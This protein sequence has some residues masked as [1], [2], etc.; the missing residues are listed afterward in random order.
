MK[1]SDYKASTNI[2]EESSEE[3]QMFFDLAPDLLCIAG[4]DGSF[5]KVNKAFT[6]VLGYSSSELI[7]RPF[8]ELIHPEDLQATLDILGHLSNGNEA[9]NF[10]NR[11]IC[12]DGSYRIMNWSAHPEPSKGLIYAA[13]RDLTE[14]RAKEAELLKVN[15]ELIVAERLAKEERTKSI[16][17]AKMASLGEM[18]AG[19]AHEINNPLTIITGMV[20]LI[21][22][23]AQDK[24]NLERKVTAI[25]NASMR[26]AK[27]ISGLRK[28]SQMNE[29]ID[30]EFVKLK[31]ILDDAMILASGK[32]LRSGASIDIV[33]DP[34]IEI[35][36]KPIEIEQVVV[37]LVS[38]A[39]DAISKN[40][41]KWIEIDVT[42]RDGL[43]FMRIKDSGTGIPKE[44]HEKLFQP[45]FTTKSVGEGTG[46]GLSI[47]RGILDHHGASIEFLENE[48]NTCFEIKFK[49]TRG[50]KDLA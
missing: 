2:F 49:N 29:V 15:N 23:I 19:I 16:Q 26:I 8:L 6:R 44:D 41:E 13:A 11:Y 17:N 4:L 42:H 14:F 46:L 31:C 22:K 5:R 43:V 24:P 1:K 39:L 20:Q 28:F 50:G 30:F 48:K 10:E 40:K 25:L 3:L 18:S 36:C 7:S 37:N 21:P 35:L 45:F 12:K 9:V 47:V 38:N 27:I 32:A 33:C 34:D